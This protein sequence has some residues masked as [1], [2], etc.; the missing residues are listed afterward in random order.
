MLKKVSF[1]ANLPPF[2]YL[3]TDDDGRLFIMTNEREGERAYW[4]NIFTKD[5]VF[6]GRFMLDNVQVIEFEARRYNDLPLGVKTRGDR[7]YCLREKD[8]GYTILTIY[9]MKWN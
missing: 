7:L 4:Y 2:R 3:F 6:I 5:R 1:A 9:K 8:S